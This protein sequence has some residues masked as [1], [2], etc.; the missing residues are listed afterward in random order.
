MPARLET[1]R[2]LAFRRQGGL[3]FYC[4]LPLWLDD[5]DAFRKRYPL[6][7]RQHELR[8]CTAEHLTARQDGGGD[9]PG[10]VVAACWVCNVRR[11]RCKEAVPPARHRSRVQQRLAAGK[12]LPNAMLQA[13]GPPVQPVRTARLR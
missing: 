4:N 8:R 10:N 5:P 2:L 3:C 9:E 11:H 7:A 13:F 12:W 6:S 1:S